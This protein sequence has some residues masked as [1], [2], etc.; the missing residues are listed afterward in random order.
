VRIGQAASGSLHLPSQSDQFL[1][2]CLWRRSR[3]R[4]STV[5]RSAWRRSGLLSPKVRLGEGCAIRTS[6]ASLSS[7]ND[8][9][10][11]G[12]GASRRRSVPSS[13]VSQPLPNSPSPTARAGIVAQTR[14][15]R[16]SASTNSRS[17]IRLGFA[18]GAP[19]DSGR[20]RPQISDE[21]RVSRDS[22]VP[23]LPRPLGGSSGYTRRSEAT[24]IHGHGKQR[25]P[26]PWRQ[27]GRVDGSGRA[28]G[29]RE[30]D[31]SAV[32]LRVVRLDDLDSSANYGAPVRRARA[33][34]P[35]D[36]S[37][38]GTAPILS[39]CGVRSTRDGRELAGSC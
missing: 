27:A 25:R 33:V 28:R 34:R 39:R 30:A 3:S 18:R 13:K 23:L 26:S 5:R 38:R 31:V 1:R 6:K 7:V 10:P 20:R 29:L 36:N 4:R 35:A 19:A 15:C 8:G 17:A 32:G 24:R 9:Q 21:V 11:S 37:S 14:H 16:P 22:V 12:T 2:L